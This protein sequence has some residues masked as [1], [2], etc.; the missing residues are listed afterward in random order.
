MKKLMM[1]CVCLAVACSLVWA[2]DEPFRLTD[3]PIREELTPLPPELACPSTSLFS[4]TVDLA[5]AYASDLATSYRVYD[6]FWGLGVNDSICDVHFWGVTARS[7][8]GGLV[9]CTNEDPMTFAILIYPDVND[10]P[11]TVACQYEL[12]LSRVAT[13]Y[14]IT[15]SSSGNVFDVV[16]YDAVLSPCCLF[17]H[18]W[19]SIRGASTV[20]PDC[21]FYWCTSAI[22]DGH[23]YQRDASGAL[24]ETDT[25]FAFCLTPHEAPPCVPDP[26]VVL[27]PND[28]NFP[29]PQDV[30]ACAHIAA[31]AV[32]KVI[33]PIFNESN[34]PTVTITSG[35]T[36]EDCFDPNCI[37]AVGWN[38][39]EWGY[40][41]GTPNTYQANLSMGSNG[42][43]CCVCVHLDYVLPVELIS[44]TAT[45]TD[46]RITL[47]W[48]TAS[49]RN[50]D[51]FD[52]L[53]DGALVASAPATNNPTGSHYTWTDEL[54]D[55][56]TTYAYHLVAVDVGGARRV[57]A[58]AS[59][60]PTF[61]E[62]TVTE[63]ALYQNYPN[64]FNAVTTF[65]FDLKETAVVSLKLYNMTGQEVA[66]VA[67]GEMSA[68]RHEV[69]F[70][71]SNLPTGMYLYRLDAPGFTMSKKM[72]L[73]K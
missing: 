49:E 14:T 50:S 10:Y 36:E 56:G 12:R 48:A 18:G 17:D 72:L 54:V 8:T 55:N 19:I 34:V 3:N 47:N 71:A 31:G 38:L 67:Q 9:N 15:S 23:G 21:R 44:F 52:V 58:T 28:T 29:A 53:R 69:S 27:N 60:T 33:V 46:H 65:A 51:R 32:T 30:S 73:I 66:T 43:G 26:E 20:T 63:Y 57:L 2:Q 45:P 24:N 22:G 40:V 1:I 64:P 42:Y 35:C 39:G 41:P 25:D 11:G 16:R 37:P 59:A 62:A 70:D 61:A 4:Q 13:G 7:T 5:N 6:N 68:G